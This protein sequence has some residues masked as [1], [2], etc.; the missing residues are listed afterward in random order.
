V[1]PPFSP[2]HC[3]LPCSEPGALPIL[4]WLRN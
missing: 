3:I 1:Q 4:S 2:F